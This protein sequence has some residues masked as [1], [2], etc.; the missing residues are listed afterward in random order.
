MSTAYFQIDIDFFDWI[1]VLLSDD[2]LEAF[3]SPV[4]P[5]AEEHGVTQDI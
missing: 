2:L 4:I 5:S 1:R 3:I